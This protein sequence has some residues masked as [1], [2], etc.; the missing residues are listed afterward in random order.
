MHP[1]PYTYNNQPVRVLDIDGE[2]WFVGSD[3]AGSLG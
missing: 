3:V 1:I 2:P